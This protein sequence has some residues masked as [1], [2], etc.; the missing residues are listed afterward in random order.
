MRIY[1]KLCVSIA[2]LLS[3]AQASNSNFFEKPNCCS[4][5]FQTI[6]N[7]AEST[8]NRFDDAFLSRSASKGDVPTGKQDSI[9]LKSPLSPLRLSFS[10]EDELQQKKLDFESLFDEV[11]LSR[12]RDDSSSVTVE[13]GQNT[14]LI[15]SLLTLPGSQIAKSDDI[16]QILEDSEE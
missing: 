11:N 10:S 13:A 4:L 8:I 1:V 2:V 12:N 9:T 14:S 6:F 16:F 3:C 15:E 7:L 5:Q